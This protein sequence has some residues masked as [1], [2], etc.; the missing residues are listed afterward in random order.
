MRQD[1]RP[2]PTPEQ[3]AHRTAQIREAW[4]EREHRKRYILVQDERV[5]VRVVRIHIEE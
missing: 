5:E 4:S 3:I 2:D 1:R